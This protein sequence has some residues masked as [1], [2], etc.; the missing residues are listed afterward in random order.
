MTVKTLVNKWS[1]SLKMAI[2]HMRLRVIGL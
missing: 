2:V 1:A